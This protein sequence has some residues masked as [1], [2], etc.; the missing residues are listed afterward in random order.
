M[1]RNYKNHCSLY[2]ALAWSFKQIIKKRAF[3]LAKGQHTARIVKLG[4]LYYTGLK[5]AQTKAFKQ[6]WAEMLMYYN[7]A[8]FS[9]QAS[10]LLRALQKAVLKAFLLYQPYV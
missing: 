3:F 9:S 6:H 8:R 2:I 1:F 7:A 10:F 5:N 4:E